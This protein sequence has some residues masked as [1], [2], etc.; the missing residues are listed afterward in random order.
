MNSHELLSASYLTCAT[1]RIPRRMSLGGRSI[2]PACGVELKA[3][4]NIPIFG[5]LLLRGR[6][7]CC[8]TTLSPRYPLIELASALVG[9]GVAAL[10]GFGVVFA[11]GAGIVILSVLVSVSTVKRGG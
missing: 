3:R 1:W 5:W 10:A 11:A 2:C 6:T 4:W 8:G 9:A 7:A